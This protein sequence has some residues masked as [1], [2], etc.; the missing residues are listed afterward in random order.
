M[1]IDFKSRRELTFLVIGIL[2]LFMVILVLVFSVRFLTRNLNRVFSKEIPTI[3][4]GLKFELER[5]E[6]LYEKGIAK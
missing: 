1:G 6:I 2:M 5:A 3:P 4:A